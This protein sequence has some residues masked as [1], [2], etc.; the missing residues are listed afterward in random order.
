MSEKPGKSGWGIGMY[1]LYGAFVVFLLTLVVFASLN[2]IQL[3]TP[4]YYS[5][6]LAYQE[7][8]DRSKLTIEQEAIPGVVYDAGDNRIVVTY[9]DQWAADEYN[10]SLALFRPSDASLDMTLPV[11]PDSAHQQ[12]V[13]ATGLA[14]GLWKVQLTWDIGD[15]KFYSEQTVYLP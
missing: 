2:D 5:Q 15:K 3:V 11:R 12:F 1:V 10:G 13:G 14:T 4:D 8:I 9:S 7:R 6:E